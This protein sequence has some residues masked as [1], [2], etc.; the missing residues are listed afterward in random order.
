MFGTIFDEI[1]NNFEFSPEKSLNLLTRKLNGKNP[2]WT[3]DRKNYDQ[4]SP[5]HENLRKSTSKATTKVRPN[6][7]QGGQK[8]ENF[9]L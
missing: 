2:D 9:K 3:E 7:D 8:I 1:W 4:V 6:Y 5:V